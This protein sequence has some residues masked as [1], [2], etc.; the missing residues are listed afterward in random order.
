MKWSV[1][2]EK[3]PVVS[4]MSSYFPN[5]VVLYEHDGVY[6]RT[7]L[8]TSCWLKATRYR[9]ATPLCPPSTSYDGMLRF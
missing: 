2:Y 6:Y 1:D 3:M 8:H 9:L 4:N 7:D 5:V